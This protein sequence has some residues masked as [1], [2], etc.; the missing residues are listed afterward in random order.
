MPAV[1]VVAYDPAWPAL[2]ERIRASV[3][4][5]V[6]D[7]AT[8]IEHVGSTSVPGLAAKPIVDLDVV[9][10][11]DRV[12]AVIDRLAS[13][14]YE[15]LGDLGIQGRE[16]FRPPARS[17]EHHLYVCP[18]DSPGLAN[19]LAFR[20]QLRRSPQLADAYGALKT[21]LAAQFA[22]DLD[23]Y[24]VAKTEFIVDVLRQ[25]GFPEDRLR[26]IERGNRR[27]S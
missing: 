3:W 12:P 10:P 13:L 5:A 23:A 2:F 19:H 6:H 17:P 26:Q 8:A 21:R 16:A 24:A 15:H 27:E 20:D 9:V 25:A 7:L 18:P 22:H 1:I 4:P 14:G 11:T